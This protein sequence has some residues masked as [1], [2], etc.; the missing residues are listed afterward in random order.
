MQKSVVVFYD[1]ITGEEVA[2]TDVRRI[3]F[4]VE[5]REYLLE[6]AQGTID[7]FR[8][9]IRPF[10][11][12]SGTRVASSATPIQEKNRKIREWARANDIRLPNRGRIPAAIVDQY[13]A[14]H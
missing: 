6:G 4:S 10:T 8:E 14:D 1:D 11:E 7:S 13:D 3:R 5:N 2:S 9:A 12:R